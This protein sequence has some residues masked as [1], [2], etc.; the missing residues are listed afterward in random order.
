MSEKFDYSTKMINKR[1][2]PAI[3]HILNQKIIKEL[4]KDIDRDEV[5]KITRE[6]IGKLRTNIDKN[7]YENY[8][9]D[10]KIET[11]CGEIVNQARE[12]FT[13]SI[14][15]IHNA[16]GII[17]HTN[18]GRAP[19]GNHILNQLSMRA[20]GY[21]NLEFDLSTA[22][23]GDRQQH[24]KKYFK[25][26][27]G[28]EDSLVVNNTAAALI[29]I[30]KSLASHPSG[31]VVVSR[32]ELIEIGGSFRLPEIMQ[33]SGSKMIE[34]GTT[35]KTR[36]DDYE[37]AITSDT[38]ILF[39]AHTSN[40]T[41]KGYTESVSISDLVSLANKKNLITV[42]DVGSG[43]LRMPHALQNAL[44][45]NKLLQNALINEPTIKEIISSGVDLVTFSGDKLLGGPQAGIIL[46]KKK[47]IEKLSIEP[48]LRA[49]RP[50]KLDLMALEIVLA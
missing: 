13:P 19:L 46:G 10:I 28:A 21:V 35:N 2:L 20:A 37:R 40:Y 32:G 45:K 24:L 27:V 42:Y 5:V 18:I 50:G 22:K 1:E 3:G 48:L 44:Q 29:L 43:L 9:P 16:T 47:L 38:K 30:L 11:I 14:L 12:S 26:I 39:K 15:K 41:I 34:V 23:R 49:L 31:E 4:V 6:I 25:N 17:L 7:S 33:S 8:T 36:I